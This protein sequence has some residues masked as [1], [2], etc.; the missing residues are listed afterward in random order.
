MT[1]FEKVLFDEYIEQA[2]KFARSLNLRILDYERDDIEQEAAFALIEAIQSYDP[3][4]PSAAPFRAYM[5][6]VIRSHLYDIL[7]KA[8]RERRKPQSE[9]KP[10]EELLTDITNTKSKG[11]YEVIE[12]REQF[13]RLVKKARTLTD[14]ERRSVFGVACGFSYDEIGDNKKEIDNACQRARRKL[15]HAA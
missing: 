13:K 5:Y 15:A 6:R 1:R 2:E 7:S 12:E 9:G 11:V 10:I 14:L 8:T 4:H 3:K